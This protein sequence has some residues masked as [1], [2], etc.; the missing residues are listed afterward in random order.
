MFLRILVVALGVIVAATNAP[1]Q[2]RRTVVDARHLYYAA[3]FEQALSVLDELDGSDSSEARAIELLR[4]ASLLALGRTTEAND[5]FEKLV[6]IA[7]DLQADQLG[8]TPWIAS[9]FSEVRDRVLTRIAQERQALE[10]GTPAQGLQPE[11]PDYYTINDVPSVMRPV[12]INET[13]PRPPDIKSIDFTGTLNVQVDIDVDGS[14]ERVSVASDAHPIYREMVRAAA[15]KWQY[16]PATLNA[17]PVKFR[18]ALT[19]EIR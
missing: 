12:A 4:A 10:Q 14:V 18:K 8:M 11:Q 9:R 19:I 17:R 1:A 2:G 16:R 13:I 3:D 6:S 7:P 15:E 5:A